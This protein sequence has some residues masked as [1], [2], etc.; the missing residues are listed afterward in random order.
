MAFYR[1]GW[2]RHIW[3][4]PLPTLMVGRQVSLAAQ[5]LFIV[6]TALAKISILVSY[7]RLAP[8]SSWFRRLT[9]TCG[10]VASR[11]SECV[12]TERLVQSTPCGTSS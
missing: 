7:L 10:V 11:G 8:S 9:S 4:S 1:Y 3:D 12:L 6:G 2:D 5:V